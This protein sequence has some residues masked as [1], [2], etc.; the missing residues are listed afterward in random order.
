VMA[1]EGKIVYIDSYRIRQ[2]YKEF[3]EAQEQFNKE[4]DEWNSEGLALQNE[5]DSLESE[6]EKKRLILSPA[7]LQEREEAIE[8]KRAALQKFTNDIFGPNGRAEQRNDQLTKPLLDRITDVLEKIAVENNYAYIFDAV[9]GNISIIA[10]PSVAK[11]IFLTEIAFTI[12]LLAT[13]AFFIKPKMLSRSG[14]GVSSLS[15]SSLFRARSQIR[16]CR[17]PGPLA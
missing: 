6:L 3:Q 13:K 16:L 1:Q 11:T 10:R 9:N 17:S 8:T 12:F 5:L 2:E 7:K 14:N 4:I 15:P